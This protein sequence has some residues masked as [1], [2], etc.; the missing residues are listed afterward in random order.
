VSQSIDPPARRTSPSRGLQSH[1][2]SQGNPKEARLFARLTLSQKALLQRAA[3]LTDRT[4]S[5]FTVTMAAERAVQIIQERESIALSARD[6]E[7]FAAAVLNPVA[8]NDA[9]RRAARLHDELVAP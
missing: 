6:S 3:D 4:L 2:A 7:I 8:P 1:S 9:L 5:E